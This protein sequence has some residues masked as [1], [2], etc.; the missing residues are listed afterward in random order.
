MSIV[1]EVEAVL[2]AWID[3]IEALDSEAIW[4]CPRLVDGF[5]FESQAAEAWF[6]S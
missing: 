2:E 1:K 3:G 6:F 4:S 5:R